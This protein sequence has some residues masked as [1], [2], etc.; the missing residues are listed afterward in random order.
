MT[1]GEFQ[2]EVLGLSEMRGRR[3]RRRRCIARRRPARRR[4]RRRRR[5]GRRGGFEFLHDGK[6]SKRDRVRSTGCGEECIRLM[7]DGSKRAGRGP[8]NPPG[9]GSQAGEP[10]PHPNS[11]E[12]RVKAM[13]RPYTE[14]CPASAMSACRCRSTRPSLTRFAYAAA[15]RPLGS[16]G[17]RPV[18]RAEADRRRAARA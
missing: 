18:W 11:S 10:A 2:V 13:R 17:A 5:R 8:A 7:S 15:S 4:G 1:G 16:G 9:A 12:T 14:F 6:P 3:R